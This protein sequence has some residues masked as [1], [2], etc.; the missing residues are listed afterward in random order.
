MYDGWL[1]EDEVE[2]AQFVVDIRSLSTFTWHPR[3]HTVDEIQIV[4]QRIDTLHF[5]D[6]A[7][8][9][10]SGRDRYIENRTPSFLFDFVCK[11]LDERLERIV[12]QRSKYVERVVAWHSNGVLGVNTNDLKK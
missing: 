12:A 7:L 5:D 11:L 3:Q 8:R 9:A 6:A 4:R 2:P 1:I 10:A